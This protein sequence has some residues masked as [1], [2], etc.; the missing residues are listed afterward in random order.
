MFMIL[1][2]LSIVF[3]HFNKNKY[4]KNYTLNLKNFQVLAYQIASTL[5]Q[6]P[7]WSVEKVYTNGRDGHIILV[8]N[9]LKIK[10]NITYGN[11]LSTNK[12][13]ITFSFFVSI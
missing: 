2:V 5:L 7:S 1:Y 6:H 8:T 4:Y 9:D 11:N 3:F 12:L 13:T 10:L